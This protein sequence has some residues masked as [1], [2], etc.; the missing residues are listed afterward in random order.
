[1]WKRTKI[2][3]C[4]REV[5]NELERWT[6]PTMVDSL[7]MFIVCDAGLCFF[8]IFLYCGEFTQCVTADCFLFFWSNEK[9]CEIHICF[10]PISFVCAVR[11][12]LPV[13][14]LTRT[15]KCS[16]TGLGSRGGGGGG[17]GGRIKLLRGLV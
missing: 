10:W 15:W 8:F 4:I 3:I 9:V 12:F 13:S 1:M 2:F 11:L 6:G 16:G 7:F 5:K 17:G 14:L